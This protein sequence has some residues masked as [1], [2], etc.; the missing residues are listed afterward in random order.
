MQ[1]R[2]LAALERQKI[3]DEYNEVM[4]SI[5][6]LED[7]LSDQKKMDRV[8]KDELKELK[9]KFGDARR[10]RI[11]KEEAGSFSEE[12]LIPDEQVVVSMTR[13]GY[14][15]RIPIDTYKPQHRG[16][17]GVR[18]MGT[19]DED[20]VENL[21]VTRTHDNILFFTNRGRVFQLKV[22]ELPD[23]GRQAKGTPVINLVQV[24]QNEKV[25]ATL[26]VPSGQQ[27]GYLVMATR[28]GTIKRTDL[29]QFQNVRRNGLIAISL[30]E[31]DELA[32]V[33]VSGGEEDIIIVTRN[34]QS[35]VFEQEQVRPIGR[36]GAGVRGIRLGDGDEVIHMDLVQPNSALLI[37]MEGGY[38]KRTP[39]NKY[40]KQLRGGRGT[41]TARITAKTGKIVA[42]RVLDGSDEELILMSASGMVTRIDT[43]SVRTAGRATSGVILMR[44]KRADKVVSVATLNKADEEVVASGDS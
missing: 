44:L 43:K 22:Y 7:L 2:R 30:N 37:I 35:I 34:G 19:R 27:A 15:K 1:L 39:L 20:E 9:N 23:T 13:R 4:K 14:V 18:G 10:T 28:N 41:T 6:H 38:G 42:A 29:S 31:G 8:I 12:D 24:E 36:P 32:W 16:G 17:K 21:F 40:R 25:T 26:T 11:F 33:K 5:K 3:T